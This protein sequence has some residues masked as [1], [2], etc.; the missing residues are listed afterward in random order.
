MFSFGAV[1]RGKPSK[2]MVDSLA[3]F[4][5]SDMNVMLVEDCTEIEF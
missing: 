4:G 5:V 2:A 1:V 3:V